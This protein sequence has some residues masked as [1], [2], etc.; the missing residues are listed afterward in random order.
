MYYIPESI[1]S[2]WSYVCATAVIQWSHSRPA[3]MA[4]IALLRNSSRS[5]TNWAKRV[6]AWLGKPKGSDFWTQKEAGSAFGISYSGRTLKSKRTQWDH[7]VKNLGNV[8]QNKRRKFEALL[9]K[10]PKGRVVKG[11]IW[12]A[13]LFSTSSSPMLDRVFLLGWPWMHSIRQLDAI[14]QI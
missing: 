1:R 9:I 2:T 12:K 11:L 8:I 4:M 7:Q 3:F 10:E 6:A 5:L 14:E 13:P